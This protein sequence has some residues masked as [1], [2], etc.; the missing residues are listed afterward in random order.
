MVRHEPTTFFARESSQQT[1]VLIRLTPLR[2][3]SCVA[4]YALMNEADSIRLQVEF[5]NLAER[6][7]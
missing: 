3:F 1:S 5:A 4:Q 7:A 2:E 6:S